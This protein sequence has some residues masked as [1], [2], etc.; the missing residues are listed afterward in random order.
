MPSFSAGIPR[1][2]AL[3]FVL[4]TFCVLPPETFAQGPELCLWRNL[5]HLSGCPACGSVRALAAFFHGRFAEAFAF[6]RNVLVTAP[7]LV[8]L[9]AM[10]ALHAFGRIRRLPPSNLFSTRELNK[11]TQSE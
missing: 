1:W 6:N 3:L 11:V 8:A 10:D 7:G 2:L 9:L 5:L 4:S